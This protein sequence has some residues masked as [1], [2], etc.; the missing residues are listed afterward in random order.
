PSPVKGPRE[1]Q[2]PPKRASDLIKMFEQKKEDSP[3]QPVSSKQDSPQ[4]GPI[5][6][7]DVFGRGFTKSTDFSG[8]RLESMVDTPAPPPSFQPPSF[9]IPPLLGPKVPSPSPP[10]PPPRSISPLSGVRTM[11]A[12]WRARSGSPS[13]RVAGSP[14]KGKD[15][16]RLLGRDRGWNV[17]IRRRR[18]DEGREER[19]AEQGDEPSPAEPAT[20]PADRQEPQRE[21]AG[22][23]EEHE[24]LTRAP[25]IRTLA[26]AGPG[27]RT[28]TITGE[29]LRTGSL[30]YF[31]VHDTSA[32]P[33]YQWVQ[34]DARLYP[35]ALHL[36][37]RAR[38]GGRTSVTLDLEFCEEVASTYS[39]N[40]P[41][42]GNDIGAVAARRQGE[43]AENLYPFQMV[44]DDGVERLACDSARERVR[45]VNAI[46]T[47]LERTRNVPS[48]TR[49]ASVRAR[50]ASNDSNS[51]AGG[52]SSTTYNPLPPTSPLHQ[53]YTT[54]DAVIPTAGGLSAPIVQ[55]GSR[56]LAPARSLR[57]VAS[58]ADLS[59]T[60]PS[61]NEPY[62]TASEM[63]TLLT[64]ESARSRPG[65]RDF[66][67][68]RG[69][70]PPSL[71]SPPPHYTSPSSDEARR[72]GTALSP[73]SSFHSP[74]P[75]IGGLTPVPQYQSF[76]NTPVIPVS[77]SG[78]T[79]R[80]DPSGASVAGSTRT[81]QQY[82]TSSIQQF[83]G[84]FSASSAS[85]FTALQGTSMGTAQQG[86]SIMTAQPRTSTYTAPQG[87]SMGTAPLF[88]TPAGTARQVSTIAG[89][90]QQ[91]DTPAET[92]QQFST[93]HTETQVFGSPVRTVGTAWTAEGSLASTAQLFSL[94]ATGTQQFGTDRTPATLAQQFNTPHT[95]IQQLGTAT[96]GTVVGTAQPDDTT[97]SVHTPPQ[98]PSS[99]STSAHTAPEGSDQYST[100][101]SAHTAPEGSDPSS[102]EP[103]AH[104][105]ATPAT[106]ATTAVHGT[107]YGSAF[108][109]PPGTTP[110]TTTTTDKQDSAGSKKPEVA[111]PQVTVVG[112]TPSVTDSS[113]TQVHGEHPSQHG[114]ARETLRTQADV[115][116]VT[117]ARETSQQLPLH[118][119]GQLGSDKR[120][121]MISDSAVSY[122]T[123]PPPVPSR[124]PYY[125]AASI[126]SVPPNP[127]RHQLY[128]RPVSLAPLRSFPEFYYDNSVYSTA[129][130]AP[131]TPFTESDRSSYTTAPPPPISRS[132][133]SQSET[134]EPRGSMNDEWDRA[135]HVS[136]PDS[137]Y[138]VIAELER[139]SSAGSSHPRPVYP[140]QRPGRARPQS[141][142]DIEQYGTAP[143]YKPASS[144]MYGSSYQSAP[145]ASGRTPLGT[146]DENSSLYLT[147]WESAYSNN[148]TY[149]MVN[150]E[151]ATVPPSES[152]ALSSVRTSVPPRSEGGKSSTFSRSEP[153]EASF[154]L[155]MSEFSKSD[156]PPKS[157]TPATP[158]QSVG[159]P[160]G[161]STA[162]TVAGS[163]IRRVP[164]PVLA[165]LRESPPPPPTNSSAER[166]TLPP[167][168][169]TPSLA[170]LQTPST[171]ATLGTR[172][173]PPAGGMVSQDVN[174]LLNYLQGQ[175][176]AKIGQTSRMSNQL[177]RIEQKI[178]RMVDSTA[179]PSEVPPPVPRK[180]DSPPSSPALSEM[181]VSTASTARPVTPPPLIMPDA[182]SARFDQMQHL[183]GTLI[184]RTDDL[185]QEINR[186]REIEI[187]MSP[188][189]G[190]TL[191]RI[192]DLLRRLL[193][194]SGDSEIAEEMGQG[195]FYKEPQRVFPDDQPPT[196]SE[197]EWTRE[198]SFYKGG[199]SIYSEGMFK[200]PA[201]A[202]SLVS[203]SA[204]SY[205]SRLSRV[206]ESL[207][208]GELPAIDFDEEF[209]MSGLPPGS[210][211]EEYQAKR[212][213]V[214][215]NLLRRTPRQ[216]PQ[217]TPQQPS[218][219]MYPQDP[220]QEEPEEQ[221][222][223]SDYTESRYEDE[224]WEPEPEP[225]PEQEAERPSSRDQTPVPYDNG[226]MVPVDEDDQDYSD[227]EPS[228]PIRTPPPP[229]PVHL[230]SPVRSN[231]GNPYP[232]RPPMMQPGFPGSQMGPLPPGA[233]NMPPRSSLPRIA[234]V[235]DPISTTYFRRGFPPGQMG[236]M[237]MGMFPGPMGMV[238]P[239]MGPFMPGLRPMS[240][241]GGPIG[242]N[243]MPGPR[244]PGFWPPGVS[245]SGDY[246]LPAG[247][248]NY[249]GNSMGRPGPRPE[250]TTDD[251]G[252]G[253]TTT[254]STPSLTSES[255]T[256]T[257]S[258]TLAPVTPATTPAPELPMIAHTTPS[259]ETADT[260]PEA[261]NFRRALHN[262]KALAEAQGEQ[263]NEMS[264][265]LHGVSDQIADAKQAT[266]TELSGILADL[267]RLK[268]SLAPRRV[269][270]HVLADGRVILDT[271]EIVE[272]IRGAPPPVTP[273]LPPTPMPTPT[274]SHVPGKIL[275]D[276]TVMAGE[277]IVDNIH[278]APAA[279][280]DP[281]TDPE[282]LK[283]L[284]A[285]R[286]LA[287]LERKIGELMENIDGT[288]TPA[289][290]PPPSL[291]AQTPLHHTPMNPTIVLDDEAM[292]TNAVGGPTPRLGT[293]DRFR[294][295]TILKERE[296][297]REGPA[298]RVTPTTLTDIRGT[299]NG[300]T[301]V[302]P[303]ATLAPG[304]TAHTAPYGAADPGGASPA[305]GSVAPSI[306]RTDP[307]TGKA[308][309]VPAPLAL[310][311]HVMSPIVPEANPSGSHGQLIREEH[312]EII[313]RPDGAPP[314]HTHTVTRTY[315]GPSAAIP[316]TTVAHPGSEAP[317]QTLGDPANIEREVPPT[318][319]TVFPESGSTGVAPPSQGQP[320]LGNQLSDHKSVIT[321]PGRK[322]PQS[323]VMHE[324]EDIV[325]AAPVLDIRD[326]STSQTQH[327]PTS[328][329]GLPLAHLSAG[330]GSGAAADPTS[331]NTDVANPV[332]PPKTPSKL[333]KAEWSTNHP[334]S[335]TTAHNIPTTP[336][337]PRGTGAHAGGSAPVQPV[338]EADTPSQVEGDAPT[339]AQPP[340]EQDPVNIPAPAA[341]PTTVS[342]PAENGRGPSSKVHF[343]P[344]LQT[345]P[346]TPPPPRSHAS[347]AAPNIATQSP[348]TAPQ[349]ANQDEQQPQQQEGDMGD[350]PGG[351]AQHSQSD[352]AGGAESQDG[353]IGVKSTPSLVGPPAQVRPPSATKI[354]K[355]RPPTKQSETGEGPPVVPSAIPGLPLAESDRNTRFA[356][357]VHPDALG[358]THNDFEADQPEGGAAGAGTPKSTSSKLGRKPPPTTNPTSGAGA[359][360]FL[361]STIPILE[362]RILPDGSRVYVRTPAGSAHLGAPILSHIGAIPDPAQVALPNSLPD[363]GKK[364]SKLSHPKSSAG[365]AGKNGPGKGGETTANDASPTNAGPLLAESA[366][367]HGHCSVCC[368]SAPK[369]A[370]G[371][372]VEACTHQ[373]GDSSAAKLTKPP[374]IHPERVP[375]PPSKPGSSSASKPPSL[376]VEPPVGIPVED[377]G[378]LP[379]EG[380]ADA[381]S[382][383]NGKGSKNG[384]KLQKPPGGK[385]TGE[386]GES[387]SE[388]PA[389]EAARLA[390]QQKAANEA[391]TK[392]RAENERKEAKAKMAE[393]RHRQNAEAL[394]ALSKALDALTNDS[395]AWK[396]MHDGTA[397][398]RDKRRT[399]K[400]ARD[401]K[402]QEALDKLVVEKDLA[403]K[404]KDVDAK[405]PGTQAILD[406][407]KTAGDG[408]A[409]FL[410]KLAT[411]I[412]EHNSNQHQLTQTAAKN[413]AREQVGFNLAGYLDDFSK[414]LSGEVRVLLK[415]VGDLRESRRA[416]YMEL[417]ELLLMKG[418]QS[419]GDLMAILPYPTAAPKQPNKDNNQNNNN[420]N[421]NQNNQK[422]K[423]E[424]PAW[425]TFQPYPGMPPVGGM[426]MPPLAGMT[427]PPGMTGARP[428]PNPTTGIYPPNLYSMAGGAVPAP[429]ASGARPLPIPTAPK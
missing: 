381:L 144:Q 124:D 92:V 177:D 418:R 207:L 2:G 214:P 427:M 109:S 404:Q 208:D 87:T 340:T 396:T 222:Q 348:E 167:S 311:P 342:A 322:V 345:R 259:F 225:E 426:P 22:N 15:S 26:S 320:I 106:Y 402:W 206:P 221:Y 251:T 327:P 16:S 383:P 120:D 282:H 82:S 371:I 148:P 178:E 334:K 66:T 241:T 409:A 283:R 122:H 45:W 181:S 203:S 187:E 156:A 361:D 195:G 68:A 263:Q 12:S 267:N 266:Q 46:W 274:G 114:S 8:G 83:G 407:F 173:S 213:E 112:P 412:T 86:T 289:G 13:Q 358:V 61:S 138:G 255:E 356:D 91:L 202:N 142:F 303:D 193:L 37:C 101:H 7:A 143:A 133:R 384:N 212:S 382:A 123:A 374:S 300:G 284:E 316:L 205:G 238:G 54:D 273:G 62:H 243:V 306:P 264:R 401:K 364:P 154:S 323:H 164:V 140:R 301:T 175:D 29:P 199:D 279:I 350:T 108:T 139:Q 346:P 398:D 377:L 84:P 236:P 67:F 400:A 42:V 287:D 166:S 224:P 297:I 425:A 291:P 331:T 332:V 276:G 339:T 131:V 21:V 110:A 406:A 275:P 197:A 250:R 79:I 373:G 397:K 360:A 239:G 391:A 217:P 227:Y 228:R 76:E 200:A 329:A 220:I 351:R 237:G 78:S 20:S 146:A 147:A 315:A 141:Y 313:Q 161:I 234:G 415:E 233:M 336:S 248:R 201:P 223:P 162:Q 231:A 319:M 3:A 50:P 6:R 189:R 179:R 422:K 51:D 379:V 375:L 33:D 421:Q 268:D 209:A 129:P 39:P 55:R 408:Q 30:Y 38:D 310:T 90:A 414:A 65:S 230:P 72:F 182:I 111:V 35:E 307:R 56:R 28:S 378:A 150:V 192:E 176:E 249:P 318:P 81:A 70:P 27:D 136:D 369:T 17:S 10:T 93:M 137:D 116:Y 242:P 240:A 286:Q 419:A 118:A 366:L 44:Y 73:P 19:L 380:A 49:A 64:T 416:L 417:A 77:P 420:N 59:D 219:E 299:D 113:T 94:Q 158:A 80:L 40:N 185:Q 98:S 163:K 69:I 423:G 170:S 41:A 5:S 36:S 211:P 252:T 338:Q 246:G 337:D 354:T 428:L 325:P 104:T 314:T 159:K 48:A 395:K 153:S 399:E 34:V 295:K 71:T 326:E 210:P 58:E 335:T 328:N 376:P 298:G 103:S 226:Q 172:T 363:E 180:D 341:G 359:P 285:E 254:E 134:Q 389:A 186:K 165:P 368:P 262:N 411:E 9:F 128:D 429:P 355:P 11:I 18:K 89:T 57:R 171:A 294:E 204:R 385:G 372:P 367:G 317:L 32:A 387:A 60:G 229:Q 75:M 357:T 343:E 160:A 321:G 270:A 410:R 424:V 169:F 403:A 218:R 253:N 309:T 188:P 344:K 349:P 47:A 288:R 184:G 115:E 386:R 125:R 308:L 107:S 235:R 31:H 278:G 333:S 244:R 100:A 105:A 63:E 88:S 97:R 194:H 96:E 261:E 352:V 256:P 215:Q 95:G 290:L 260:N 132:S 393:E 99:P 347:G 151:T 280:D 168:P 296:I 277:K 152:K 324:T 183:L 413:W 117:T 257:P 245:A 43:I 312:E 265:Y 258:I 305:V 121:S 405:K 304:M 25:S 145:F 149:N 365:S 1:G 353:Q 293:M 52:S 292:S 24:E 157:D 155:P 198:G 330:A 392:E 302:P 190:P 53:S 127:V 14:G 271:G 119:A 174:R 102:F 269:N 23:N 216:Q 390:V 126:P 196:P 370:Q 388:D 85:S 4:K 362:E 135:T 272:G 74:N 281:D 394:A 191:G 130:P 247:A 232:P